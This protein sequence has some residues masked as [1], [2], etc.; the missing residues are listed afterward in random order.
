MIENVY[1]FV[2]RK[3]VNFLLYCNYMYYIFGFKISCEMFWKWKRG[4]DNL[5]LSDDE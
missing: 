1:K 4:N 5:L 2:F 3:E